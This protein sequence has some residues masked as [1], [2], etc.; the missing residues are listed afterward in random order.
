MTFATVVEAGGIVRAAK[1]L[2]VAQPSVS[3]TIRELEVLVES[4]LFHKV[5]RRVELTEAGAALY[6][7][8]RRLLAELRSTAEQLD[9]AAAHGFVRVGILV[10]AAAQLV[11]HAIIELQ[12]THPKMTISLFEVSADG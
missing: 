4:E 5:G 7:H 3:R 8:V 10:A 11:P 12:R 2:G 1:R 9:V 6:E